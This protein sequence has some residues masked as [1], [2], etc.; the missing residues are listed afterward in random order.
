MKKF[1][2]KRSL[3]LSTKEILQ[4]WNEDIP[5]DIILKQ[6]KRSS[7]R[8]FFFQSTALAGSL[9]LSQTVLSKSKKNGSNLKQPWLTI[10]EVQNHLFPR[11]GH[12]TEKGSSPSANDINAIGYLQLILNTPDADPDERE[13]VIKGTTWLDGM[14]N[15]MI[16]KPFIK[17]NKD[18]R[19]RVLRK[20]S[21][22]ESGESWLSTLLRY[23]FEALL[24]DPVYRGN[25]NQVGWQWLEHQP[26]F[27]RPSA[28]KKY[29]LLRNG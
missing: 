21:E 16:G 14:A 19:E 4:A 6:K 24:T 10:S 1:K 5:Q 20:I 25:T 7:R 13:F 26:G 28:N 9:A 22:S 17:L 2:N 3:A 8:D 11:V 23:I 29:W 12:L 18:E 27:P 15:N